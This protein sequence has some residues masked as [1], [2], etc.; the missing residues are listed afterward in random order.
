M[1]YQYIHISSGDSPT[2]PKIGEFFDELC[3]A[4][5]PAIEE[6]FLDGFEFSEQQFAKI[7][8]SSCNVKTLVFCN[9]NIKI[10]PKKST[11]F[12]LA[13]LNYN[14]EKLDLFN[15]YYAKEIKNL[16][17]EGLEV[18]AAAMAKTDLKDSL[19]NIH[20]TGY[21]HKGK[22][23]KGVDE[24][25]IFNTQGLNVKV[26]ADNEWSKP[27]CVSKTQVSDD[28]TPILSHISLPNIN[29]NFVKDYC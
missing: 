28:N 19:K 16:N 17:K 11:K 21:K 25:N 29:F 10:E 1:A 13:A 2:Y 12:S 22:E 3:N 7:I 26:T 15:S 8:E 23:E 5:K 6:I 18:M 14:I 24:Q 9:C 20:I 4:L 27:S